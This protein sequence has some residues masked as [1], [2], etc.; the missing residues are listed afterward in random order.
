M[1]DVGAPDILWLVVVGGDCVP[2]LSLACLVMVSGCVALSWRSWHLW[3][4][5]PPLS[6]GR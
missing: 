5:E 2:A 3:R 4:M 6:I 1:A